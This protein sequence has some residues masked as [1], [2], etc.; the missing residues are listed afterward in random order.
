MS[1]RSDTTKSYTI[2]S[3][4]LVPG[5]GWQTYERRLVGS[6]FQAAGRVASQLARELDAQYGGSHFWTVD[7]YGNAPGPG[8]RD[9]LGSY[10]QLFHGRL[11]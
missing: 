2:V 5:V 3:R 9:G 7:L 4:Y 8:E 10:Y 6:S 1:A 11:S